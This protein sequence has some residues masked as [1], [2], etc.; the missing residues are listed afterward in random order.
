MIRCVIIVVLI[1]FCIIRSIEHTSTVEPVEPTLQ[2]FE[3]V[4]PLYCYYW[5]G[6]EHD[7]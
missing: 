3:C 5:K 1:L 4:E 6:A 2:S 7:A